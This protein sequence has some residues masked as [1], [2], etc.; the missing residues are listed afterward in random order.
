[1]ARRGES[2]AGTPTERLRYASAP[3]H[4]GKGLARAPGAALLEAHLDVAAEA[5]V[6]EGG[7]ERQVAAQA[8]VE[9]TGVVTVNGEAH[10]VRPG[11]LLL[12]PKGCERAIE[13]TSERFSYLSA[14]RRRRGLMPTLNGRPLAN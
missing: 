10:E 8:G 4:L 6:T 12:I 11:V 2:E 1:M 13:S 3:A 5:R 7:A 9:G 14:H